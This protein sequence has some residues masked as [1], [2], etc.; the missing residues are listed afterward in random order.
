MTWV[1]ATAAV[2]AV[3][4]ATVLSGCG[5]WKGLNSL[6][7]PGTEG[8][9]PGAYTISAQMPDVDNI[10]QNSRVRVGDVTVGN[11]TKIERQ[12]WN[13]LVTMKLNGDVQLPANATATIG[14]TSLLGSLHVELAPPKNVAPEGRLTDGSVIPLSSSGGYPTTEQ[15]LAAVSLLLN[16][17]GI[18][19]VQDITRTL[20]T[21][22][23]GREG[24]LRSLIE[25]LDTFIRYNNDQKNDIIAAAESLNNLVGQFADQKPVVDEALRTIPDALAVL[26][27]Q[28]EQLS[29]ALVQL[30]KFS[31]FAADSV[32]QTRESLV[33]ELKDLGPVLQSLAD[34]GPALTRA[35]SFFPTFPWPKETLANWMRGDY[36]NLSLVFDLTLSR[37]DAGIFTGTRWEG[38]LTELELQWGRTIG[39]LPS[40]Y[41]AGNPLIAPYRWDQGR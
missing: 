3:A 4:S 26:R 25:Q 7:M 16:G 33:A 21:A 6:P 11:V 32:E 22:F 38:D 24:D 13:A 8:T 1:R 20:S 41:T 14:Q 23:A 37:L 18:A 19:Q 40:P 2:A 36:G 34:A 12:G 35:L 27:D 5:D 31:A 10:E 9:G 29:E 15:T 28:R 39:Q 30:G 17:G